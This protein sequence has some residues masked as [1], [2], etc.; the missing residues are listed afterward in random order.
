MFGGVFE[1]GSIRQQRI[2]DDGFEFV[3]F[4]NEVDLTGHGF[5]VH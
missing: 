1:P 4:E 2:T 3:G 5:P